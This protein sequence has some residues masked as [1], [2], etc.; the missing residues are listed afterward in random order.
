MAWISLQ[1]G[2]GAERDRF[3]WLSKLS[4]VK[5]SLSCIRMSH[6]WSVAH[7][8]NRLLGNQLQH[9]YDRDVT[10]A[11]SNAQGRCPI[12]CRHVRDVTKNI[13]IDFF[14]TSQNKMRA[15]FILSVEVQKY[16]FT[17]NIYKCKPTDCNK[18]NLVTYKPSMPWEMY[19]AFLLCSEKQIQQYVFIFSG[20]HGWK[21]RSMFEA[22]PQQIKTGWNK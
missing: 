1:A 13:L 14:F 19:P 12:L 7:R 4:C 2:E 17:T 11:L 16:I 5:A 15:H 9:I 10:Q 8:G 18:S 6:A 22:M 20:K 21:V 3:D